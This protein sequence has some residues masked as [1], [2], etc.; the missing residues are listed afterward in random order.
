MK[1][2]LLFDELK[3]VTAGMETVFAKSGMVNRYD[4]MKFG[5]FP[6]GLG[7]LTE[8]N[9]V[10][11]GQLTDEI[12]EGGVMVLGNDFGTIS[13]VK[14][15]KQYSTEVGETNSTTIKNILN[16]IR[17]LQTD[18]TFFTNINLGIRLDD[19]RFNGT[20]MIKRV[21]DNNPFRIKHEYSDLCSKFF[22]TQLQTVKPRKV[23]CLGHEVKNALINFGTAFHQWKPKSDSLEK[24]YLK[25]DGYIIKNKELNGIEFIVIPHPSYAVN[26]LKP[27]YLDKINTFLKGN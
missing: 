15:V 12:D 14:G 11:A 26:L 27:G 18:K 16:F 25:K 9:K 6:L 23:I 5:F 10:K 22:I 7:I 2:Q 19:G 17:P 21:C 3:S 24:L 1:I 20:T 8:N 13:Y 4:E